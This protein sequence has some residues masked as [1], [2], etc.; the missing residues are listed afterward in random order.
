MKRL[1][2]FETL[3]LGILSVMVLGGCENNESNTS[4]LS[5]EV[6]IED[7]SL[8]ENFEMTM[9]IS[10]TSIFNKGNPWYFKTAK[11]GN[12]W[13]LIEYNRDL[14]DLSKQVTHFYKYISDN[15]YKHY[16][17]D[18]DTEK[19]SEQEESSFAQMKKDNAT[20]FSFLYSKPTEIQ[21]AVEETD[22]TY[23]ID[24]TSYE[25]LRPA[26]RYIYNDGLDVEAVVDAEYLNVCLSE[27][28]RD[29]SLIVISWRAYYYSVSITSWDNSYLTNKYFKLAPGENNTELVF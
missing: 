16:L 9:Q 7:Y 23:D 29:E 19:W 2:K 26:K 5:S 28:Q 17:Y 1:F 10:D 15:T 6:S 21:I 14:A 25:S 4:Y 20:N 18:F 3:L 24:P 22:T 12:D 11:I 8:P 27:V 13:Q